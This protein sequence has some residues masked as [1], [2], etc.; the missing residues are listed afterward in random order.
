MTRPLETMPGLPRDD[1]GPVFAEPWQAEAFALAARLIE[2]D[3]FTRDEWARTL[4][5]EIRAAQRGGDP[6]LGD[7]YY[8]HWVR[9]LARLM[10]EK[11]TVSSRELSE[12]AEQWRRAYLATPHGSPVELSAAD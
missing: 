9:A 1:D 4:G 2:L 3:V 5:D 7:T 6:D 11:G 8:D 10:D 12:R